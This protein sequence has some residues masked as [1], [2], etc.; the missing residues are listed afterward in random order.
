MAVVI[1]K[2]KVVISCRQS[3]TFHLKPEPHNVV[4]TM[5]RGTLVRY[6]I[7]DIARHLV[8]NH[9]LNVD[10]QYTKLS[11]TSPVQPPTLVASRFQTG[12]TSITDTCLS[13]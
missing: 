11:K 9:A 2:T 10:M 5:R 3:N 13:R 6:A 12:N 1:T 4:E 8:D 7:Y